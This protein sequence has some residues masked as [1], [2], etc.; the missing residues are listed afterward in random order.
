MKQTT[1][2]G[3][4]LGG[5]S[6]SSRSGDKTEVNSGIGDY[7]ILKIDNLGKI[8]C[9]KTYGGNGDNQLYVIHKTKD[10]G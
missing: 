10:G 9:Q 3:Y 4:I 8:E 7:W 1:D 2:G 5:Y 6:N